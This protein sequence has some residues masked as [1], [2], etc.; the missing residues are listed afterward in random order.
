MASERECPH[1]TAEKYWLEEELK[2]E[3]GC[4]TKEKATFKCGL[5]FVAE[6]VGG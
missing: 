6:T 4:L 5:S 3:K 2:A 1:P